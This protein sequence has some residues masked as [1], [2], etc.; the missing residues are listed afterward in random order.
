MA[1]RREALR[2]CAA[3]IVLMPRL[4]RGGHAPSEPREFEVFYHHAVRN[5]S[6]AAIGDVRIYL[7]IPQ[8]EGHQEILDF[9]VHADIPGT[10]VSDRTDAY[11][12]RIKRIAIPSLDPGQEADIGFS[13]RVRLAE[14][15][16]IAIDPALA[17]DLRDIPQEIRDRYT[18]DHNI[19]G[20]TDPAIRSQAD[21]LLRAHPNP[22]KRA[23]AIHDFVAETLEYQRGDGW[24]PAPQVLARRSGSCSEFSYLFC[25]LCRATDL[26]TRFVGSSI[27]SRIPNPIFE[28]ST[29]HRWAEVYLP[30]HQWVPFDPTL[31]RAKKA[32]Q[33]FVGMHHGRTL[34]LTRI[35]SKSQQLGLSYL[36][37]NSHTGQT[38][39]RRVFTWSVGAHAALTEARAAL[40]AGRR[41]QARAALRQIM[42][43]FPGTAAALDAATLLARPN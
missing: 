41:T 38:S 24:D 10:K 42:T 8:T 6:A 29:W 21:R 4:V 35:G 34:I 25:A 43:E 17:G 22:A 19:F 37:A 1:T 33:T 18:I 7:P 2:A 31:D 16:R 32:K 39:R 11:G 26:P 30:G 15:V 5:T 9:G 23:V 13:C 36:G 12:T 3:G 20:L 40:E 28:D 14:P 27:C